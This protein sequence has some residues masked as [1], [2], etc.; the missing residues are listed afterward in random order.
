ARQRTMRDAIAWSHDLLSSAEQAQ[1]RRLAVFVGGFSLEAAEAIAAGNDPAIDVFDCLASLL[2]KSLLREEDDPDGQPRFTM[3]ET[4]REFGLERLAESGEEDLIRA[5]HAMW[6]V[7]FTEARKTSLRSLPTPEGVAAVAVEHDNLRAALTF[8]DAVRDAE[9]LVRLS[10]GLGGYWY[11]HH[12]NEGRRWLERALELGEGVPSPLYA[13]ALADAGLFVHHHGD[14]PRARALIERSLVLHGAAG[15]PLRTAD[16]RFLLGLVELGTGDY[17]DAIPHFEEALAAFELHGDR[18]KVTLSIHHLGVAAFGQGEHE[19]AATWLGKALIEQRA[20]GDIF[21]LGL[22][23]DYF[24]LVSATRGDAVAAAVALEEGLTCWRALGTTERL[25]DWLMRVATVATLHGD[26][27]RATRLVGAAAA[28]HVASGS[29]WDLPERETYE[30]TERQLRASLGEEAFQSSWV[31]GRSM[32][33]TEAYDE[34]LD[35]LAAAKQA[36]PSGARER[37]TPSDLTARELEVLRLLV[38]GRSNPEIGEALFISP[39]TAQT[40][41]THILAKLGVTSRTEAAARAVR[42]GLV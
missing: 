42:D 33:T 4:V 3:L 23:L 21:G 35:A 17:D 2:D 25:S 7:A 10:V 13:T 28:A 9:A 14:S 36:S 5:A 6:C 31:A 8:F 38:E 40:H 27:D 15:D 22:T 12:R 18:G 34:G 39:R 41:V 16:A 26:G 29:V 37:V 24:G 20:G 30:Q 32:T 1:F 11:L 19:Q